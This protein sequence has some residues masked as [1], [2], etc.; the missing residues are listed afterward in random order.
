MNVKNHKKAI[1][2]FDDIVKFHHIANKHYMTHNSIIK[3]QDHSIHAL[4]TQ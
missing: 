2:Q 3:L 4:E 1:K